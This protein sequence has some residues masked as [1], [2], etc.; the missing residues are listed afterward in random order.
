MRQVILYIATTIDGFIAHTDGDVDWLSEYPITPNYNYG[1]DDFIKSIDTVILGGKSYRDI[2]TMDIEYPYRSKETYV[3]SRNPSASVDHIHFISEN[4]LENILELK[5]KKGNNIW[6]V[7]G[8]EIISLFLKAK[9]IDRMIL[10]ITP[11]ILGAGIP[12]FPQLLDQSTWTLLRSENYSNGVV[13]NDYQL[14]IE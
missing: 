6:L 3:I 9:L 5:K 10:T 11:V 8:G 2:L 4:I 7:G 1:Y 12:L 13:Q 14:N